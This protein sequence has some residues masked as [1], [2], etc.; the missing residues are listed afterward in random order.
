MNWI[1]EMKKLLLLTL[2]FLQFGCGSNTGISAK[3]VDDIV[4]N[5]RVYEGQQI[6]I[7]GKLVNSDEI[8]KLAN[9]GAVLEGSNPRNRVYLINFAAQ[10]EFG[11]KVVVTGEFGTISVPLLGSFLVLDAKSVESCSKISA[12]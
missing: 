2:I 10:V 1:K 4:K 11:T 6:S 7:T 8:Q 9:I 3:P 12:C 5:P